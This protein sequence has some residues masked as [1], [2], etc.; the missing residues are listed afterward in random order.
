MGC[1]GAKYTITR[2]ILVLWRVNV[3]KTTCKLELNSR[4]RCK[5]F[6]EAEHAIA[7]MNI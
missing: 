4:T 1:T 6:L 2:L 3:L 5:H 7:D